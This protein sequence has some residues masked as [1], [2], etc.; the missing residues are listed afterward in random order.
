[1]EQL[2]HD[3]TTIPP[4]VLVTGAT[5]M[6]GSRLLI[7][8]FK[9]GYRIRAIYREKQRIEQFE[10]NVAAYPD[11]PA[12]LSA[13]IEWVKADLLDAA[14]MLK[15][16]EGVETVYHSAAM[17]SF[18]PAR[19]KAMYRANI[20]GTHLLINA[21]I[22][23]GVQRFCH[24]SSVAALGKTE[25]GEAINE[26]TGWVPQQKNSGYSIS[27]FHA[28]M[29]VWRG[30]NEGL[31]AVIV[32]PSIILG[33]GEWESGSSAFFH[34][35]YKGLKF[36]T[37]GE[38]GF[39]DV[40]DVSA[41]LVTLTDQ[42]NWE[43][44]KNQRFLLN[45][46]NHSYHEI[47][48][49]IANVLGVPAPRFHARKPMLAV[50]WRVAWLLAKLSASSPLITRESV[51]NSGKLNRF[52]GSKITRVTGLNYRSIDDTIAEVGAMFLASL[53]NK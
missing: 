35:I 2:K 46:S 32:N 17:V 45:A 43:K 39:V 48:G 26:N 10:S 13:A 20:E 30:I 27:K 49:K 8:L 40:R 52:D 31:D 3:E 18:D 42:Q 21:A 6:L 28:E 9:K 36:Y 37:R 7:D 16:L 47:F 23:K 53:K 11:C 51:S 15:V 24:V 41:A 19:R 12:H 33:P 38:T 25:N 34:Q 14:S 1:M 50:A 4:L 44:T 5:G 22:E 29:E